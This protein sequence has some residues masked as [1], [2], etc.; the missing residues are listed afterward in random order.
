[1]QTYEDLDNRIAH[2]ELVG[3]V[4]EIQLGSQE[5]VLQSEHSTLK[6]QDFR[7]A[8]AAITWKGFLIGLS[9]EREIQQVSR[10]MDKMQPLVRDLF[11][12]RLSA[13]LRCT[14]EKKCSD[15]RDRVF[16]ILSLSTSLT[17]EPTYTDS[18][19]AESVY[20]KATLN[21]FQNTYSI[22]LTAQRVFDP[23]R[24]HSSSWVLNF[25][26]CPFYPSR[27]GMLVHSL[28]DAYVRGD[29]LYMKGVRVG[30]IEILHECGL[31]NTSSAAE[32][33]SRGAK[34]FT[35]LILM[36]NIS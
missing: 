11:T 27:A 30:V 33:T 16:A 17:L 20:E 24:L 35:T 15:E 14:A 7:Q 2:T 36:L 9:T 8:F 23:E 3:I 31:D 29:S 6:W 13:V 5:S 1:M 4:Q 18:I 32:D 19:T 26:K 25:S 12:S 22:S 28:E 34:S 21:H 10:R